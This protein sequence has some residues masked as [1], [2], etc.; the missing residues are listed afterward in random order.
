[1][2][3]HPTILIGYGAYGLR[4]LQ[5]FLASAAARGALVWDQQASVGALNERRLYA[6]SLLWVPDTFPFPEQQ[7][8]ADLLGNSGYELMD[9][10]YSQVQ[11]VTGSADEIK[12]KLAEMADEEK[13]R[14]L[15]AKRRKEANVAG[16]DVI[17]IAQPTREEI[18]GALRDLIEPVMVRLGA[19]P[20]FN[21]VQEGAGDTLLNFIEMLDFD[22]YWSP[23][24]EPV[25]YAL[26]LA[27]REHDEGF[28]AGRPT[29][30][31]VY[32]FDGT[33]AG[34]HHRSAEERLEE[35]VLFLE[36]LLLEGL[37]DST[38]T[39]SL[40]RRERMSISPVGTVGVRVVERSSGLLRRL[41]AAAF[42]RGWLAHIG[43]PG[44]AQNT[45]SPFAG[46]VDP[47]RG[48]QLAGT[49][50][51]G[52]LLTA[53]SRETARVTDALLAISP[54][55]TD[56]GV[57]LQKEA[58]K[59]TEAAIL[60]LS[61]QSGTQSAQLAHG[62]LKDF[63]ENLDRTITAAMQ[64]GA[65]QLTLGSVIDELGQLENEF[66][67]AVME[68]EPDA[69]P[70]PANDKVFDDAA[71]MQREYNM[72][73]ARQV[74]TAQ[75]ATRWWP[76]AAI[77]FAVALTPMILRGV[78]DM[79]YEDACP[80]WAQVLLCALL[81]GGVFWLFGSRMIQPQLERAARRAREFYTDKERGR[82]AERVRRAAGSPSVGG[83]I[84]SHAR[85]L[86]FGLKQY[87]WGAV[88]G[89]LQRAR[90]MLTRRQEEVKW[91]QDQV[92]E[93]LISY[94]VDANREVPVFEAGRNTGNVRYSLE[95]DEDLASVAQSV[96]RKA[97]RFRELVASNRLFESWPQPYC[98]TFLH[99]VPFLD[100]LSER[101]QDRLEL[102]EAESRRR[103]QKIAHFLENQAHVPVGFHWLAA[104]GLPIPEK[105][106]LFPVIWNSLPGV[107][108]ALTT[109][110]FGRRVVE[111]PN[112]ERLYLFESLLGVPNELL[113]R[114][115]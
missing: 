69:T 104:S 107:H 9:D 103:A 40:Y 102:D 36:L 7:V 26:Q 52:A 10:L 51:E 73:R 58:E 31:R 25:R 12:F 18:V 4:V 23:R 68:S 91:L 113:V 55:E 65:Q 39:R 87:V 70:E 62:I 33:T 92:N 90:A 27:L 93:F 75:L 50:G 83:R 97:D 95:T 64:D 56:W 74:Q 19:D 79:G 11:E 80:I 13:K 78:A 24:M 21:T 76:R 46:L 82:L 48:D 88:A 85:L 94:Q 72:Y 89:E 41:A 110:G 81:L 105:G 111:T 106:S 100:R 71:R 30:G 8:P 5:S 1:M 59:Q 84:E 6:L 67:K 45:R 96:P 29:V 98:D 109:A 3:H 54:E 28:S 114:S 60:R 86:V 34:G 101:F 43:S 14:L 108:L 42:A 57:R 115:R 20:S 16:L 22:E 61:R 53:T 17:V 32:L 47:F 35:V 2:S 66:G 37:R 15:D 99:P 77:L 63:R 38:D 112:T 44:K 49:I